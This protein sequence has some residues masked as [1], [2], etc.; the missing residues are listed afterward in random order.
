MFLKETNYQKEQI[1]YLSKAI[2]V[3]GKGHI[4]FLIFPYRA[5]Q[6]QFSNLSSWFNHR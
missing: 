1:R 3:K 6:V 5:K 2:F 4:D